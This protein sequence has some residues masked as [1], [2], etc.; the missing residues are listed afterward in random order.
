MYYAQH[1]LSTKTGAGAKIVDWIMDGAF[2]PELDLETGVM[3]YRSTTFGKA[4][5]FLTGIA[6]RILIE[7]VKEFN[8][9]YKPYASWSSRV[10]ANLAL[11][12]DGLYGDVDY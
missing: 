5:T 8:P 3:T 11:G 6:P 9:Y 2:E 7:S 1:R 10:A 4:V 12:D